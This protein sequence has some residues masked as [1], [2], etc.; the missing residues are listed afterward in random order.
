M[1]QI[2]CR[3]TNYYP[4]WKGMFFT[5]LSV[6]QRAGFIAII[7]FKFKIPRT[8]KKNKKKKKERLNTKG[9]KN[10]NREKIEYYNILTS[11]EYQ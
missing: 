8:I 2:I 11:S 6:S 7:I 4:Q 5:L 9:H 10:K 3:V 1:N